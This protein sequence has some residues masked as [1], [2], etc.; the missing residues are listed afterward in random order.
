MGGTCRVRSV[1]CLCTRNFI[2]AALCLAALVSPTQLD[3][4]QQAI[5]SGR[6]WLLQAVA[7]DGSWRSGRDPGGVRSTS[8]ALQALGDS[9]PAASRPWLLAQTPGTL[10]ELGDAALALRADLPASFLAPL[11]VVYLAAVGAGALLAALALLV[12][13]AVLL[14]DAPLGIAAAAASCLFA[15]GAGLTRARRRPAGRRALSRKCARLVL[16]LMPV[17]AVV[18]ELFDLIAGS[19]LWVRLGAATGVAAPLVG[20]L[21]QPFLSGALALAVDFTQTRTIMA[22]PALFLVAGALADEL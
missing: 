12:R 21:V 5:T 7:E 19:T 9:A 15:A 16:L 3:A 6:T 22:A 1:P 11:D 8:R 4:S 18:P 17:A 20:L 10:E 2:G 14:G 13:S